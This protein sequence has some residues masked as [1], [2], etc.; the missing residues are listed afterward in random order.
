MKRSIAV[1][2]ACI[3]I[4]LLPGAKLLRT[5]S[6]Q[7][8]SP[9]M[10]GAWGLV[11]SPNKG[12]NNNILNAVAVVSSK[13]V[14]AVGYGNEVPGGEV[15][16]V[17]GDNTGTNSINQTLIEHWNGI[18]WSIVASPSPGIVNH[19]NGVT[20]VSANDV[21]AVG[22]RE[23]S[24]KPHAPIQTLVEHWNGS[25]WGIVAS[26][27]V[28]PGDENVLSAVTAVSTKDVWAVGNYFKPGGAGVN[29]YRT[30]IEHWNGKHW[31]IVSSLNAG[32]QNNTLLGV[33]A[34]SAQDVWA[35]GNHD[36]VKDT[37]GKTLVEHWNGTT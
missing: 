27:G 16:S 1:I 11:S 35:V 8:A 34:V 30:L 4:I 14:W 10:C 28:G 23:V 3:L 5:A 21:W 36:T 31:S 33:A 25:A 37:T 24:T 2:L 7:A 6:T 29:P 9:S 22:Y 20:A 18:N 12:S 26:P 13:D 15:R 32:P 17:G 19:L